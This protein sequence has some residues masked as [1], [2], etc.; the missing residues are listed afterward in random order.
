MPD[1]I[2]QRLSAYFS[3]DV[4]EKG[5]KSLSAK[6]EI[7]IRVTGAEPAT[8]T[9][10]RADKRNAVTDGAARDP[11]LIFT[12]TERALAQVLSDPTEDLGELGVNLLKLVVS[13][14]P[15]LKMSMQIKT[16][17]M[18]LFTKGYLGVLAAGGAPLAG[19]LASKGLGGIDAIKAVL[20]KR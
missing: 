16:G 20:K 10:R 12:L 14:D 15:E 6:A 4:A 7:E 18:G 2:S 1:T 5:A 3:R 13:S 17:F 8:V 11:D 9:L 19:Y